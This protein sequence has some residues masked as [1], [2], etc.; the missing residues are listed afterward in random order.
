MDEEVMTKRLTLGSEDA[1][2]RMPFT[3]ARHSGITCGGPNVS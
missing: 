3:P 2:L 1:D